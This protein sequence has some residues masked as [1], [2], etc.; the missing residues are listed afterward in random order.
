[1]YPPIHIPSFQCQQH[2]LAWGSEYS[3]SSLKTSLHSL[4]PLFFY[5][6]IYMYILIAYKF[7]QVYSIKKQ[8]KTKIVKSKTTVSQQNI[9]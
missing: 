1:M 3:N 4:P 2:P 6:Y 7:S 8:S 5:A 9:S